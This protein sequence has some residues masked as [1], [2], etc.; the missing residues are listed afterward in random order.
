MNR[1]MR[2]AYVIP[3]ALGIVSCNPGVFDDLKNDTWVQLMERDDTQTS[4]DFGIAVTAVPAA[5]GQGIQI[6]A[7][8]GNPGG[9][10]VAT[11]DQHGNKTSQIGFDAQVDSSGTQP[12]GP[13]APLTPK[14]EPSAL[15]PYSSTQFV[16]GDSG[17]PLAA[18]FS[19]DLTMRG[20][21]I[22]PAG[23]MVEAG[24]SLAVG[25]LAD[26]ETTPDVVVVSQTS[27]MVISGALIAGTAGAPAIKSCMMVRPD[28]ATGPDVNLQNVTTASFGGTHNLIVVGGVRFSDRSAGTAKV[29]VFD[30]ADFNDGDECPDTGITLP[31]SAAD[32]AMTNGPQ[33]VV[34]GDLDG[35]GGANDIAVGTIAASGNAT[36]NVF[37]NYVPGGATQPT[38][39]KIT[40]P[41]V[42]SGV[43]GSHLAIVNL[44]ADATQELVVADAGATA[45]TTTGS[46]EVTIY[47]LT[48]AA[49]AMTPIQTLYDPSPDKDE[50]FGRDMT[51]IPFPTPTSSTNV[52]AVA[53]K[54]KIWVYFQSIPGATDPRVP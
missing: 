4:G 26:G 46:G 9:L 34:V 20:T 31:E 48:T 13:L 52:L 11:F 3:L 40:L 25:K 45:A 50:M 35:S 23:S 47:K 28:A 15:V 24:S 39:V 17:I 10:A 51:F 27:V 7:A 54:D 37:M 21:T 19:A 33:A 44:D 43:F 12:T 41:S 38:P 14:T 2:L 30:A 29:L 5:S 6:I 22:T 53:S 1:Y 36:V 8:A 42:A 32:V 18:L 16:A 49:G